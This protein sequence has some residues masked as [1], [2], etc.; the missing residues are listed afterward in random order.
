MILITGASGLLGGRLCNYLTEQKHP[1]VAGIRAINNQDLTC[2][3]KRFFDLENHSSFKSATKKIDTVLHLAGMNSQESEINKTKSFH[4]VSASLLKFLD[5]CTVN[6]VKRF[7]YF[8]S[9][10]VYEFEGGGIFSEDSI[11]NPSSTYAK[12]HLI[13]EENLINF[14][15]KNNIDWNI[16]RLSNIFGSPLNKDVNCW[17]LFVQNLARSAVESNLIE[18]YSNKYSTRDFLSINAFCEVLKNFLELK[19]QDSRNRIFN[20]SSGKT[21]PLWSVAELLKNDAEKQLKTNVGLKFKNQTDQNN[22]FIINN[23]ALKEIITYEDNIESEIKD[24]VTKSIMWFL[25]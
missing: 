7:I 17:N 16:F 20:L 11:T 6:G 3:E 8:S 21:L 23:K 18:I 2:Q 5:A 22:D 25:N 12:N 14:C 10:Q 19:S 1:I 13:A 9:A 4:N 24:L 15:K